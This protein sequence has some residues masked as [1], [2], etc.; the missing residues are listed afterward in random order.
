[1]DFFEKSLDYHPVQADGI[2]YIIGDDSDTTRDDKNLYAVDSE[3]GTAHWCYEPEQNIITPPVLGGKNLY[4]ASSTVRNRP[5][6][7]HAVD[8][9]TGNRQWEIEIDDPVCSSLI[10]SNQI[11]Y[12][13]SSKG[14]LH[15][16]NVNTATELGQ[17]QLGNYQPQDSHFDPEFSLAVKNGMV[18]AGLSHS[19]EDPYSELYAVDAERG[20]VEWDFA[21]QS[22]HTAL[23]T[24]VVDGTVYVGTPRTLYAVDAV[25]GEKK[26]QFETPSRNERIPHVLPNQTHVPLPIVTDEKA[27]IGTQTGLYAV[28]V[29]QGTQE[30]HFPTWNL[31]ASALAILGQ[32]VCVGTPD[33][34]YIVDAAT[35]N[36]QWRWGSAKKTNSVV[37]SDEA[38]CMLNNNILRALPVED[39]AERCQN[40]GAELNAYGEV[41]YCPEC[42]SKTRS[43]SGSETEVYDK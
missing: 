4:V 11:V 13:L 19:V 31:P 40:C 2:V 33:G 29:T 41:D 25:S 28:D 24:T 16:I 8:T 37:A 35:G 22:D 43:S 27:Y 7:L 6:R 1:M 30:W 17:A 15:A 5:G 20:I 10:L 39:Y 42:G 9:T 18:Y 34:L 23:R 32:T 38:I 26:W 21:I 36:G 12:F 14:K 3:H